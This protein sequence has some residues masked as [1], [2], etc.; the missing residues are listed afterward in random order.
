M[1]PTDGL[2]QL[3]DY[4]EFSHAIA[5]LNLPISCSELHGVLCGYLVAGGQRDGEIY[6]RALLA[7]REPKQTREA[8]L[9]L[10][11][12]FVISQ[13]QLSLLGFEFELMLP[14]DE[15]ALTTRAQAF[16]E[17]CEGFTQGLTVTGLDMNQL[18]T[19]DAQDAIQHITEFAQLDYASLRVNEED[20]RAFAEV[21]EYTRMAVLSLHADLH[22]QQDRSTQTH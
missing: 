13:H 16:S 6:L 4:I 19:E 21:M 7:K 5:A 20:E 15:V 9:A 1:I 17:W 10:F 3:P 11:D 22:A 12:L 18:P 14:D 2:M 8:A